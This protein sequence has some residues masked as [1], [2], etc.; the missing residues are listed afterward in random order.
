MGVH[1]SRVFQE[2]L[3]IAL[4]DGARLS[5]FGVSKQAEALKMY[6][7]AGYGELED[8]APTPKSNSCVCI[9]SS[10]FSYLFHC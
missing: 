4:I 5:I 9:A 3:V 1:L 10:S 8:M 6:V 2:P 7:G